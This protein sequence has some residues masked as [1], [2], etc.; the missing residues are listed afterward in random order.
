MTCKILKISPRPVIIIHWVWSKQEK[1]ITVSPDL[2]LEPLITAI[3]Q[4][5]RAKGQV[6]KGKWNGE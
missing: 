6:G 4:V 1:C 2:P 3:G 5:K